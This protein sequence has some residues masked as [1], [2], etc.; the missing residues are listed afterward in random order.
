[1]SNNEKIK[2]KKSE[3]YNCFA[4]GRD[5]NN[6]LLAKSKGEFVKIDKEDISPDFEGPEKEIFSLIDKLPPL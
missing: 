2:I 4:C 1:M 6:N 3:G 5:N